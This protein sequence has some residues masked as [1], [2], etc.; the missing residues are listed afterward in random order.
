MVSKDHP[1]PSQPGSCLQWRAGCRTPSLPPTTLASLGVPAVPS[2]PPQ[3]LQMPAPGLCAEQLSVGPGTQ[4][5]LLSPETLPSVATLGAG[6]RDRMT[7]MR[8]P[9]PP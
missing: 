6:G 4:S 3:G 8:S 5:Q 7:L 9:P 2:D 1:G